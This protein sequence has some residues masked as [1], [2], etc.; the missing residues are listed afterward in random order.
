MAKTPNFFMERW[1]NREKQAPG[2]PWQALLKGSTCF[3]Y[4]YIGDRTWFVCEDLPAL[5]EEL[6]TLVT[7]LKPKQIMN[8]GWITEGYAVPRVAL[9]RH[10][11]EEIV[12]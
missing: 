1:S 6:D 5:C 7:Q 12:K 11:R 8:R 9:V 10:F 4:L 2:G 3:V